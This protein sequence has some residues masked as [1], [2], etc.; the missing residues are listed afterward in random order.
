LNERLSFTIDDIELVNENEDSNFAILS[1][2]FFASGENLHDLYVSEETL[3]R[4]KNTI[5]NC[6]LVWKY[7][8]ILDDVYTH[9]EDEVPCGFVPEASEIKS[10]KLPDGRTMLSTIAYVWKRYTGKLLNIFQRDGGQKPVSVEMLV[11]DIGENEELGKTELLDYRFEGITILGSY[12]T[13]AI[14]NAGATIMSYS[15]E[16]EEYQRALEE[17]EKSSKNIKVAKSFAEEMKKQKEKLLTFPYK[18]KSDMNPALKGIK[19]PITL[20]QANQIARVA[21]S[22]GSDGKKNGWAIAIAQFKKTHKVVDGKWVKKENMSN[23]KKEITMKDIDTLLEMY[24]NEEELTEEEKAKV[25]AHLEM[26]ED[27]KDKEEDSGETYMGEEKDKEKMAE[28]SKEE[29]EEDDSEKDTEDMMKDKDTEDMMKDKEEKKESPDFEYPD[30]FS[31]EEVSELFSEDVDEIKLAK[32]ETEKGKEADPAIILSGMFSKIKLMSEK[33]S[34]LSTENESLSEF[35]E[36]MEAKEKAFEVDKTFEE[37]SQKV[38]IPEEAREEMLAEAE[39]YSLE[40]IDE[41]K[42]WCKAKSFEFA[43]VQKSESDVIRVGMPFTGGETRKQEKDL[44]S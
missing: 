17:E 36:K 37:L 29:D 13:P 35:K 18:S 6:P 14:P 20:G 9:D 15:K 8:E 34:K 44:W 31:M 39:K 27:K 32:A 23:D 4:T 11:Y 5:K 25:K 21:D 1:L 41:W 38:V 16:R 3:E 42:N 10:K 28:D 33:I 30:K 12:V 22:V 43:V 26:A 19:P 24:A 7:D 40:N 2:D